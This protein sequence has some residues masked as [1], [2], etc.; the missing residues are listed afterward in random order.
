M[1]TIVYDN[2]QVSEHRNCGRKFYF[3]HVRHWKPQRLEPALAFGS[4]WHAGQDVIWQSLSD[5]PRA[6][7]IEVAR[8]ATSAF[9]E[10]YRDEHEFD[11]DTATD[12]DYERY[13]PRTPTT[14]ASM[15]FNYVEARR[16]FITSSKLLSVERPFLVPLEPGD[17][18]LMYCGKMDKVV[19]REDGICVVEHKTTSFYQKAGGFKSEFLDSFSPN[20]QIDGYSYVASLVYG[21]RFRRV[22]V[23]GALVHKAVHDKFCLVPVDR[24]TEQ[25]EQWL[26]E[27]RD[28]IQRM[29]DYN[30]SLDLYGAS[31]L[32]YLPAFPKN[33][34]R[35]FDF[36]KPCSYMDL[37][38]A[39]ANP[40][41][42]KDVPPGFEIRP[43][44]PFEH[45]QLEA[46][47][48]KIED[49][50]YSDQR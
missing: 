14:A 25:L 42:I 40:H 1:T 23:D 6:D 29:T 39:W 22:F 27:V 30:R 4:G 24:N 11:W 28:E 45:I 37:C 49:T 3:A 50:Q 13:E 8:A 34:T 38:K 32:K 46:L 16:Q 2:T 43:W 33:T 18:N 47:G 36:H 31:G 10:H 5:D 26:W 17:S 20:S 41:S 48:L 15:F 21:K 19:E 12:D 7:S 35:C 9:I 44:S